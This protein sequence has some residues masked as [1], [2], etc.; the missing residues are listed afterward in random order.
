MENTKE[1]P[2]KFI[3][4]A[5]I[6]I[7]GLLIAARVDYLLF[8]SL[9]ELFSVIIA[10]TLFLIMWNSKKYM[11]NKALVFISIA[12]LFIAVMD[13]LHTLSYQGMNIFKDYDFYANQLW[14]AARYMESLTLLIVFAWPDRV[15][16]IM[17]RVGTR[18]ILTLYFL[19]TV[20]LVASTFVLTM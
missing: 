7:V 3:I 8:H 15:N 17:R 2:V 9:A 18:G 19:I 11:A 13:L 12:Y 20:I 5:V 4:G 16:Q 1:T 10:F 14:I 6:V